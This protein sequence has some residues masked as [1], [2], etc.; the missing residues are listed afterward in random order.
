MMLDASAEMLHV[1][2]EKVADAIKEKIVN[3]IIEDTLP[4]LPFEDGAF[5]AVMFN[6]YKPSVPFFG[7]RQT[8]Q[9]QIRR[10]VL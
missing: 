6:P 9:T 2:R 8:V 3:A 5:D 4:N 10:R 1:A 7:H